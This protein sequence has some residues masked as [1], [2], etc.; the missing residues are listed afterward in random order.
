MAWR[1]WSGF[2]HQANPTTW[3][4]RIAVNTALER[5]RRRWQPPEYLSDLGDDEL[6][7]VDWSANVPDLAERGELRNQIIDAI[8]LLEPDQRA[9]LVLR[10]IDGLSTAEAAEALD[11][12]E[13]ALKSRLHRA[14]ARLAAEL[15]ALRGAPVTDPEPNSLEVT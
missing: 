13:Q 8:S 9:A 6:A 4:Y 2:R 11:I 14:R 3:F 10:D 7:V 5:V 15:A 1:G 12:G